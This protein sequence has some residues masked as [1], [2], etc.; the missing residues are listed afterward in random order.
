M[1]QLLSHKTKKSGCAI[2][3]GLFVFGKNY[4]WKSQRRRILKYYKNAYDITLDKYQPIHHWAIHQ[5]DDV[6]EK[7]MN[8]PW[9]LHVLP[10]EALERLGLPNSQKGWNTLHMAIEGRIKNDPNLILDSFERF[11]FGTPQSFQ[12]LIYGIPGFTGDVINN[13]R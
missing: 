2:K 5:A 13:N 9:N 4:A 8:Q 1:S 6:A 10:K 3:G 12:N 11:K 7:V